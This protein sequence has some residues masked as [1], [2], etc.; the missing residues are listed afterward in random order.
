MRILLVVALLTTAL[1]PPA[2][3]AAPYVLRSVPNAQNQRTLQRF[4]PATLE[5]HGPTRADTA[6]Y[7][8]FTASPGGDTLFVYADL[9]RPGAY[10]PRFLDA[11]TLTPLGDA[12]GLPC[13]PDGA[14]WLRADRI[15]AVCHSTPT[16]PAVFTLDAGTRTVIAHA[17]LDDW[18]TQWVRVGDLWAV[19]EGY[20]APK[21]RIFD[22]NGAVRQVIDI[23]TLGGEDGYFQG[24]TRLA[25]SR[26]RLL[27]LGAGAYLEVDPRSGAVE[28]R[29]FRD[30]GAATGFGAVTS[31]SLV[32]T[33]RVNGGGTPGPGTLVDRR[34]GRTRA[35]PGPD[36]AVAYP[37]GYATWRFRTEARNRRRGVTGHDARGRVTWRALPH[38]SFLFNLVNATVI[39]RTLLLTDAERVTHA[40]ATRTGRTRG[41]VRT[42]PFTLHVDGRG[43]GSF[44]CEEVCGVAEGAG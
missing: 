12:V 10:R 24:T 4:D 5:P 11:R 37:G 30:R 23:S 1:G 31:S 13:A 42:D 28:R 39:G 35:V 40:V 21:V 19:R 25:A 7:P 38:R 15:L 36:N 17:A 34:T 43:A 22:A 18:A 20:D 32:L 16:G 27:V 9:Y 8:A 41:R 2:A 6:Q 29:A 3:G 26:G 14:V 44:Y 33:S